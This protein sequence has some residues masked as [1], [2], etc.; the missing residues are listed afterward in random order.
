MGAQDRAAGGDDPGTGLLG[1]VNA[2][3]TLLEAGEQLSARQISAGSGEPVSTV[4]RLL[5]DLAGVGLVARGTSRGRFRL[6]TYPL[7]VGSVYEDRLDLG[8]VARPELA[9]LQRRTSATVLL[10]VLR[11]MHAVCVER[12]PGRF[13]RSAVPRL[14]GALP[15]HLGAASRALMANL[16]D[17]EQATVLQALKAETETNPAIPS[18]AE[19]LRRI[20]QDRD[21]AY[22]VV[23]DD[24]TPGTAGV[25]APVFNHRGELEASVAVSALS[26]DVHAELATISVAVVAAANRISEDL[27]LAEGVRR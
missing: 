5:S 21:R 22:A 19:L 25:A 2:I 8:E 9:A 13:V 3:L 4:Y 17:V 7:I 12:L 10:F 15:L 14:G 23:F 16:D 26:E 18:T 6:G 27:G 24:L 1:R 11:D 20:D